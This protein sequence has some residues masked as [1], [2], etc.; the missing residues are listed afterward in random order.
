LKGIKTIIL[1]GIAEFLR[2]YI[3]SLVEES[4]LEAWRFLKN[5]LA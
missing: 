4:N 5:Y 3:N 1:G 2:V